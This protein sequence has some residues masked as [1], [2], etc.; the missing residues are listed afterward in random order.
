MALKFQ[1]LEEFK[2]SFK[3]FPT[4]FV[5][6]AKSFKYW[7][8]Y[9]LND[10]FQIYLIKYSKWSFLEYLENGTSSQ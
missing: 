5:M 1:H 6:P 3:S 2:I 4:S 8:Y 10:K 7:I 9:I